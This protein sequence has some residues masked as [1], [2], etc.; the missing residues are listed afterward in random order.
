MKILKK[1]VTFT[2]YD[3]QFYT[4]IYNKTTLSHLKFINKL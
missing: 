2:I 1:G 4:H 3:A